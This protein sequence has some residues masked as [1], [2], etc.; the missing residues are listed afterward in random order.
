MKSITI[1]NCNMFK[2]T[3][4]FILNEISVYKYFKLMAFLL[5]AAVVDVAGIAS[6]FPLIKL[7]SNPEFIS[8]NVYLNDFLVSVGVETTNGALVLFC[9]L[10]LAILVSAI[11]IKAFGTHMTFKFIFQE[12]ARLSQK[13]F[14][15]YSQKSYLELIK[16]RHSEILQQLKDRS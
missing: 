5:I 3:S 4:T 8:E 13:L 11:V 9:F 2:L 14:R 7:I 12:E 1:L 16:K 15:I 10:I 6:V